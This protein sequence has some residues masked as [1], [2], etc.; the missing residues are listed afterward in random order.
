M[1]NKKKH[2]YIC[3]G[4]GYSFYDYQLDL[5]KSLLKKDFQVTLVQ[6]NY[7]ISDLFLQ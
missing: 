6:Y 3:N 7:F 5:I 4:E 1:F 2:L